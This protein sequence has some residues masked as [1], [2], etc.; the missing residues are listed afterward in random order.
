MYGLSKD[1]EDRAGWLV[2]KEICQIAI[3]PYD[4]Q[5]IWGSGGLS[6]WYRLLYTPGGGGHAVDWVGDDPQAGPQAACPAVKRLRVSIISFHC[7]KKASLELD[8]RTGISLR[9][10]KMNDTNPSASAREKIRRF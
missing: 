2:G 5:I 7:T 1:A 3:G 6:V 10:S 4:L 8:S 9:S